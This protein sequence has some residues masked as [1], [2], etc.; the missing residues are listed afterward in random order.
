MYSVLYSSCKHRILLART[1]P[2][3]T[4]AAVQAEAAPT[5][6]AAPTYA[7]STDRKYLALGTQTSHLLLAAKPQSVLQHGESESAGGAGPERNGRRQ[8]A[9]QRSTSIRRN[10]NTSTGSKR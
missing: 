9:T 10:T 7:N 8:A 4:T 1:C 2:L 5:Q 6:T 3:G